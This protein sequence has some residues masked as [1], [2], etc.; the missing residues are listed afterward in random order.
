MPDAYDVRVDEQP[1]DLNRAGDVMNDYRTRSMLSLPIRDGRG[2]V[3]GVL[4]LIN[5]RGG[6]HRL[7]PRAGGPAVRG[8]AQRGARA[9]ARLG[10]GASA[11]DRRLTAPGRTEHRQLRAAHASPGE[12]A[13][14]LRRPRRRATLRVQSR[15]GPHE[16]LP[17]ALD[18]VAADP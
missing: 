7:P 18:A 5:A 9:T 14:R 4:Q 1:Y 10:G 2:D 16:R 13:R 12:H 6:G 8:R 11:P 15:V 3:V 17:H